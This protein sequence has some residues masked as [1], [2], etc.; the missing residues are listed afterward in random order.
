MAIWTL[1]F[2]FIAVQGFFLCF[3]VLI[4]K[5]S[6]NISKALLGGFIFVFS[7]ILLFW[8]GYW[9]DFQSRFAGFNFLYNPIPLLLGPLFFL[10]VESFVRRLNSKDFLHFIPFLVLAIYFLPFYVLPEAD[11]IIILQEKN[12]KSVL[13]AIDGLWGIIE[14]L[15][16][17][18]FSFYAL[19][20]H[21]KRKQ[22][23]FLREDTEY[24]DY[25]IIRYTIILF[26]VFSIMAVISFF[27]L[28]L[29]DVPI[30]LDFFLSI[31]ICISIYLIGY[32]Q[33]NNRIVVNHTRKNSLDKYSRSGLNPENA[34]QMIQEILK[35]LEENKP[36]INM[37]YKLADLAEET[38]IPTHHISELLNKY[39]DKSFAELINSYRV[40]EAKK[41]LVLK[42]NLNL[43]VSAI[44][45]DVGF[46]SRTS[47][48]YWFKKI[49][50][51]SP[52]VYQKSAIKDSL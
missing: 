30:Y 5:G 19:I 15:S 32:L 14:I 51:I 20:F 35:H 9:N 40:E 16:V 11:K 45:Y 46:N 3:L 28:K 18:S 43:K 8:V 21:V 1:L 36:Y 2:L 23:D 29:F 31:L 27:V 49:T 37:D 52:A 10:Y 50:N 34:E 17:L 39:H 24:P 7:V 42:E 38:E 12:L 13:Y 41:M 47:F 48:Y 6:K 25:R 4:N 44:G 22:Y 33:V 26:T